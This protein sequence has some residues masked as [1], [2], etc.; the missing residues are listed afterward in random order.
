MSA[1]F[2]VTGTDTGIGKTVFSA[3]LGGAL[4]AFYWK[5][6]QSGLEEETDSDTVRR[7]SG[8]PPTRILPEAYRMALPASPHI[9]AAREGVTIEAARL[10]LPEVDGPLVVEGA[11]GLLA[12][13]APGLLTI[14]IFARMGLPVILCARTA[15]GTINH[16]LLSLEALARRGIPVHGVAFLGDP[17]EEEEAAVTA[18]SGARRL[19]RLPRVD[20]LDAPTLALAFRQSFD[21]DAF[22]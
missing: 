1:R 19:G 3:A 22:R 20:P 17:A 2:I 15:L 14:D 7:L 16:T 5:P 6:V 9:S 12:P 18:F 13:L 10:E 4:D 11:G 8:L 21:L